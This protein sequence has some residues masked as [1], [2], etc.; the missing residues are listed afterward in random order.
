[1]AKKDEK[2]IVLIDKE[3][4]SRL[5]L[6][7]RLESK[8]FTIL[9]TD[10]SIHG[11]ELAK[12]KKPIFIILEEELEK[13]SGLDTCTELKAAAETKNIPVVFFTHHTGTHFEE[14]CK[15]AG[16]IGI[17]YKPTIL[18]LFQV[19]NQY[20]KDGTTYWEQQLYDD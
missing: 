20:L 19:M 14:R 11:M 13:K 7:S 8:G 10:D 5:V 17:V 4:P 16:A 2:I 9:E 12:S 18:E 1:M 6:K 3:T 15:K